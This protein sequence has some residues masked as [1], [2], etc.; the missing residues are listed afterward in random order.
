MFQQIGIATVDAVT[1]RRDGITFNLTG[2]PVGE[3][4]VGRLATDCGNNYGRVVPFD[5]GDTVLYAVPS[6]DPG[7]GVFVIGRFFEVAEKVPQVIVDNPK[8]EHWV[9][10]PERRI[11]FQS[12]RNSI[13]LLTV[14]ASGNCTIKTT[15]AGGIV[16]APAGS[17]LVLAGSDASTACDAVVLFTA[18]ANLFNGHMHLPGTFV[19]GPN[20]VTGLSGPPDPTSI[21]TSGTGIDSSNVWAKK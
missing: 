17:E 8:D 5:P 1:I 3:E 18:L 14:A 15:S 4:L 12:T 7:D 6:G 10:K 9:A 21:M 2:Q 20:P 11:M 19:I 13:E 16:L